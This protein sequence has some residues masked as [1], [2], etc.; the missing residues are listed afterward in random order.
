MALARV[1]KQM[2]A[3]LRVRSVLVIAQKRNDGGGDTARCLNPLKQPQELKLKKIIG[4]AMA[5]LLIS[6]TSFAQS[7]Q[8]GG[9]GGGGAGAGAAVGGA[10][11][12]LSIGTLA[13]IALGIAALA[14]I[15]SDN[16][17]STGTPGATGARPR[18]ERR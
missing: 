1:L 11:G 12:G 16:D 18:T 10:A 15:A 13:A 2:R 8:P 14:A 9:G 7:P 5:C 6:S 17:N 4:L 3:Y